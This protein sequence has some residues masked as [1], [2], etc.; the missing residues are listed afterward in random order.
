MRFLR[1]RELPARIYN[2]HV[3]FQRSREVGA[4]KGR[5]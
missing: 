4:G 3:E 2:R 5:R 1:V